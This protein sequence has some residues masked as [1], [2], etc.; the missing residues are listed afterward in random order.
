MCLTSSSPKVFISYSHDSQEHK[1]RVLALADR[2]RE[3]GID[4][5]VDQYEESPPEG[6]QRWMLSQVESADRVL[7]VCTERYDRRFR[8]LE[9][10]GT[11]RGVTWEGGVIIQEIYDA[12]GKNSKFIPI[13]L[14]SED[15]KFIPTPLRSATSYLMITEDGYESLYRCLTHQP[16]THKPEIG[17]LRT[18][19]KSLSAESL[20]FEN[21][22][23]TCLSKVTRIEFKETR[24]RL[25]RNLPNSQTSLICRHNDLMRD[26]SC[27]VESVNNFEELDGVQELAIEVL[28][29]NAK[30]LVEGLTK[31]D[32][33]DRMLQEIR[34]RKTIDQPPIEPPKKQKK[35]LCN[36]PRKS[37]GNKFIGRKKEIKELLRR[38]S[39]DDQYRQ[40]MT[41]LR[42]I[43]GV[44][45][46]A[47]AVEVAYRCW[48]PKVNSANN[49]NTPVFDA[50]IFSSSK[51]T[52][53]VY[54]T[55]LDRPEKE[56]TLSDIFRVISE[57]LNE[58]IITQASSDKQQEQ[59]KKALERQSTLLIVDN[60][61]TLTPEERKKTLAFLNNVPKSTQVIITTRDDI[62]FGSISIDSLTR[63]ESLRLISE[64]AK[65]KG[66]FVK[67][68]EG[69][70]IYKRFGGI[71][72]AL[73]YAVGQRAAGYAFPDI[74]K[75]TVPLP[76]DLGRFCFEGS[77]TPLR[78]TA[79]HKLLLAMTFFRE[80]PCRD[81]LIK[82]AGL[83]DRTQEVRD[84]LA[85]LQQLSLISEQEERYSILSITREYAMTELELNTDPG[86]KQAAQERWLNWYLNFTKQYGGLDWE[87]W[88]TRYDRLDTE[89]G[90]IE[91]VLYF[92]AAT[93]NWTKVLEL[94]ENIDNYVDLNGY[95]QKRRHWWTL[96]E[97]KVGSPQIKATALSERAWT[98]ILMGTE[99]HSEAEQCLELAWNLCQS[100]DLVVQIDIANH[101]AVLA[102]SRQ[103]YPKS[104]EWL[105]MEADLLEQCQLSEPER[106]RYQVQHLYYRAETNYLEGAKDLAKQQFQEA[107]QLGNTVKWER[108]INYAQ[109]NLANILIEEFEL[110]QA[111]NLL[112]GG[113]SVANGT[114]EDRRVALYQASYARCHYQR[115]QQANQ[116]QSTN[117]EAMQ[118]LSKAQD[119]GTK[120]LHIFGKESMANE[121][122]QIED[123]LRSISDAIQAVNRV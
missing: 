27:I 120:A 121:Q 42:G 3:D 44:G 97:R 118:H 26:L 52:D 10:L 88:R 103:D 80:S 45:K 72:I 19:S 61:E 104:Q 24:N 49:G 76:A 28:I 37:Y 115:F 84:G 7:V 69:S 21:R 38:I 101:F 25:L 5:N 123:L 41:V 11:G 65:I 70:E 107:I 33:L 46:T 86:F 85:K 116:R 99:H 53:L 15:S 122:K 4:C 12:Q 1:D 71:P 6:W 75:P 94:W 18:I 112:K 60:M 74:L 114:R 87:N 113:L 29:A 96:L 51:S 111:E 35:E 68:N 89:W 9:K 62:G 8:G 48:E 32:E 22:L 105:R 57:T 119:C 2:L 64:Q 30:E 106:I 63:S 83:I 100:T 78:E 54:T 14:A 98:L 34:Q 43:G 23:I 16:R 40:H 67:E 58:A 110:D 102:Q 17:Q 77:V 91:S 82:V 90:N 66:I 109:N 55:L 36:L 95:W 93:E 20:P 79:A 13:T 108:F 39:S 92:C 50:I 31:E 47:L 117:G 73:I 56:P 59:V 81:A